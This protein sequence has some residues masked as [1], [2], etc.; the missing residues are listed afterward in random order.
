MDEGSSG[1]FLECR[2]GGDF[3]QLAGC[4]WAH[5]LMQIALVIA[6]CA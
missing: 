6:C 2:L 4:F 5:M 1:A 3:A